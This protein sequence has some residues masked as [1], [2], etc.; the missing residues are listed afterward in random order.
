MC[1]SIYA[2]I[3][4]VTAF[5]LSLPLHFCLTLHFLWSWR[6]NFLPFIN[7]VIIPLIIKMEIIKRSYFVIKKIKW[8]I[9]INHL[10]KF[11]IL[12]SCGHHLSTHFS[13]MC[14]LKMTFEKRIYHAGTTCKLSRQ[15]PHSVPIVFFRI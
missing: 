15:T 14:G 10:N 11:G 13:T 4:M 6:M 9:I 2:Y 12:S 7:L 5:T 1:D 8:H 3:W